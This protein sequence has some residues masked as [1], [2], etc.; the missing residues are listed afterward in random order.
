[1]LAEGRGRWAV[2]QKRKMIRSFLA[3]RTSAITKDDV[4]QNI[5]KTLNNTHTTTSK[6]TNNS[7][8]NPKEYPGKWCETL[9]YLQGVALPS[10]I[11]HY[12]PSMWNI[13][14]VIHQEGNRP[15]QISKHS[16]FQNEAKCKAFLL[17]ISFICVR[18]E[19]HFHNNGFALGLDMKQ[20]LV[21][22]QK[23]LID[24]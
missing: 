11:A 21:A 3:L 4:I 14:I 7:F 23:W 18:I 12:T 19:N 24:K 10:Q 6:R 8:R 5:E 22:T 16:H 20:R 2:S 15:F 9:Q 1:M 13:Q 17:K